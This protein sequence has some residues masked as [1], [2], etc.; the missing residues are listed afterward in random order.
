MG[1]FAPVFSPCGLSGGNPWK[2]HI[3]N[4]GN[5]APGYKQ[6]FDGRALPKLDQTAVEWAAGSVQE[7]SWGITGANHG[8]GYAYRLCPASSNATE[9]CFQSHHLNFE[10]DL[11]WI[12]FGSDPANRT[13][14]RANRTVTGTFPSQSQW[15]KNPIPSCN[16][17]SGGFLCIGGCK[18]PTFEPPI[19]GLWGLGPGLTNGCN[20]C[21][22]YHLRQ[23]N[24]HCSAF[25]NFTIVDQVRV[26][27]LPSGQYILSFRW[28]CEQTPQIWTQCADVKIA[29]SLTM[30]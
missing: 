8:G 7:V 4:G 14:I 23:I 10:G 21:K 25:M 24:Q 11:T 2:P 1:G 3:G 6:G 18:E 19:P 28:D 27:V 26:P 5:P 20:G 29:N 17:K 22:P 13:A 15:T 9:E 30:V 16:E 12:Q